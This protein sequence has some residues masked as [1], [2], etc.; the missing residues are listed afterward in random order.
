[1][2]PLLSAVS[3]L[4]VIALLAPEASGQRRKKKQ[5]EEPIPTQQLEVLPE[6]PAT[7]TVETAR[8][9]FLTT[10]LSAKGLLSQQV[11]DAMKA[12]LNAAKG[13]QIVKIRAFVSGTGDLR[14]VTN[15]VAEVAV[16]RRLTMPVIATVLTGGLPLEGAQIQLEATLQQKR[17]E[18]PHGLAFLS[19]QLIT[20]EGATPKIQP[21]AQRSLAQLRQAAEAA[22]SSAAS[23]LRVTCFATSLEDA[24][25]VRSEMAAAFPRAQHALVQT[26]RGPL[27]SL[28]ECE[29]VARLDKPS[30]Q[31]LA[32]LNP[33]GLP[34]SPNY[35]QVAVVSSPK[36]VLSTIQMAFRYTED[37][38]RLAFQRFDRM[39]QGGGSGIRQVAMMNTYSLSP[40]ITALV[41]KVRFDFLDPA[42]PPASTLLLF[43]G[44]PSMDAAFGLEAVSLPATP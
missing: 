5:D 3:V 24:A 35:S 40:Q 26:Q 31:P 44:L 18:N 10:P 38:A 30:T 21:L 1:M 33:P 2:K 8:L 39:L 4:V 17:P 14:R 20:A 15:V 16:D 7:L 37:D 23:V 34:S 43:E 27:E 12:L 32:L 29:G 19:G 28:C 36:V 42:R 11:R 41:R 25:A 9:G 6:P 13:A 22:G